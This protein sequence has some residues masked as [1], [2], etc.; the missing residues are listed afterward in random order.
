MDENNKKNVNYPKRIAIDFL[1]TLW[2]KKGQRVN[3]GWHSKKKPLSSQRL[4]NAVSK[5]LAQAF[6]TPSRTQRGERRPAQDSQQRSGGARIPN[7]ALTAKHLLL[8][9]SPSVPCHALLGLI[10]DPARPAPHPKASWAAA[11]MPAHPGGR[12]RGFHG[13]LGGLDNFLSA[14]SAPLSPTRRD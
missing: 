13:G 7:L 2:K 10:E 9:P 1:L 8:P 3:V 14:S 11:P 12:M 5:H 4:T 6:L